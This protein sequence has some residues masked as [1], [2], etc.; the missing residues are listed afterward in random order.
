[1]QRAA[2]EI[3]LIF[4]AVTDRPS[5]GM[6]Q[7]HP[8]RIG[9]WDQYGGSMPSGWVRWL[10]EQYEFPY[11]LVFPQGLDAGNLRAQFDVIILPDGAVREPGAGRGGEGLFGAQPKAADIPVEWR[12]RLGS[13]TAEKTFPQ[14]RTFVEEGGT[15]VAWGSSASLG[16]MLGL[17]LGN[18]LVEMVNGAE[19]RLPTTKFYIPGSILQVSVDTTNPLAYGM[20][21]Q[22]DVFY[23]NNPVLELAPNASL[24]GVRP[25]A[26]FDSREPLRSGWAWGQ[27]YL[28]G[29][30]AAVEAH[31]G[32]GKVLLFG[33]EITFRGQPHGTFKFLFNSIYYSTAQGSQDAVRTSAHERGGKGE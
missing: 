25:V 7:L 17:P 28:Q 22:L 2:E 23:N 11:E 4:T 3:G 8:V 15:I 12:N 30:A 18:H 13:I 29:G 16:E 32:K 20:E 21:K 6:M 19:R 1:V 27:A 14:F 33:A 10:M 31:M 9:L 26:W 5:G 24:E